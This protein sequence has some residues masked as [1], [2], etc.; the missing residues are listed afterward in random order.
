M[1][2]LGGVLFTICIFVTV[3]LHELGHALM[4]RRYGID[5][6]DITL[7]P[8]G[9]VARLERM[10][11][12]P[13][14]ELGIALAGPAVNV[15]LA[16]ALWA[17][18]KLLHAPVAPG[19]VKVVGGPFLTKL[20]WVNV[21]LA[22]FNLLPAFPMDGG[23]ALRAVLARRM[24]Y[25]RATRM[26]ARAGQAMALVF[27]LVGMFANPMLV[28]IAVFVWI[29]AQEEFAG[30]H[31]ESVVGSIPIR[32]VMITDFRVLSP[33]DRLSR[34]VELILGGFQQD[35]P[36]VDQGRVVGLVTRDDVLKVLA[37]RGLDAAVTEAMQHEFRTV[38]PGEPVG[39]VLS[40]GR[41]FRVIL[42]MQ[43]GHLVGMLT[44]ENIQEAMMIEMAL[45]APR[46]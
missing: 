37:R 42:V 28:L 14:H 41:P 12:D 27:A 30:V 35:F 8:I 21:S 17:M 6:L 44:P 39:T 15:A 40:L 31:L 13:R 43:D 18:L 26:A 11:K 10:P 1:T 3:V 22:A 25:S 23:R 36:V 5:T 20:L 16:L 46:D 32:H 38:H 4:A 33:D 29:A 19:A 9:G 7:L 2:V 34:A 24:S 45:H